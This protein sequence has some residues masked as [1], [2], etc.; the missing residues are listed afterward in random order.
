M[1]NTSWQ[2]FL[3]GLA[4]QNSDYVLWWDPMTILPKNFHLLSRLSRE[5]QG[6]KSDIFGTI[7]L[8]SIR[9]LGKCPCPHWFIHC[10][11]ICNLGKPQYMAQQV[12]A[13]R[14]DDATWCSK[15]SSARRLI[16]EKNMLV[17]CTAVENILCDMS[18]VPTSVSKIHGYSLS[19]MSFPPCAKVNTATI[20][21]N[22]HMAHW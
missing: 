8:A 1:V 2:W 3:E 16:Y 17:N 21:M 19:P 20:C 15:V 18:L 13:S 7:L 14:V 22:D 6:C 11:Q 4:A 12:I 5:V 9:N 10:D